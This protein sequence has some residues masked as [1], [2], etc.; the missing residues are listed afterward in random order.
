MK[1]KDPSIFALSNSTVDNLGAAPLTPSSPLA[2]SPTQARVTAPNHFAFGY[3]LAVSNIYNYDGD[4]QGSDTD[5]D[6]PALIRVNYDLNR[7]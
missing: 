6:M 2:L 1:T 5:P 3:F 4:N 7:F